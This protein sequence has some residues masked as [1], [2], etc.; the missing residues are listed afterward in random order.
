M[1]H[2]DIPECTR[3]ETAKAKGIN[4]TP[5][6]EHLAHI[7]EAVETLLNPLREAGAGCCLDVGLGTP[8]IRI[9]SGYFGL[10]LNAAVG[11]SMTSAHCHGY[12]F[13]L[14]PFNGKMTEFK[15]FCRKFLTD[16]PFDQLI[17]KGENEDGLPS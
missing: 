4:N 14:I 13:D 6:A 5:G 16:H 2:F 12:A 10:V 1:K 8:G 3:S 17:S 7:V 15:S 9:S 11:G